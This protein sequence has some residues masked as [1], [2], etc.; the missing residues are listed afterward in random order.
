MSTTYQNSSGK[1]VRKLR[2]GGVAWSPAIQILRDKVE[3]WILVMRRK[4][5]VRTNL[6]KI[7]RL[8]KRTKSFNALRIPHHNVW[9]SLKAAL[10]EYYDAKKTARSQRNSF[11]DDLATAMAE[12]APPRNPSQDFLGDTLSNN[13]VL[14]NFVP[15]KY[16]PVSQA[17]R[18]KRQPINISK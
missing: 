3:L 17:Q 15:A 5:R 8:I 18:I 10:K 2:M 11:L 12:N 7:R 1:K 9:F 6:T 13:F 4:R 14:P 16:A